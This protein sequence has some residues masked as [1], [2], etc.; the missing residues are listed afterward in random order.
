MR[1]ILLGS[2]GAGKGT[3]AKLLS[4]QCSIPQI[5]TGDMLR[6]A[7]KAGTKLGKEVQLV[8]DS[9]KL[10]SDDLIIALVKERIKEPDCAEGFL[11]DGFPRTIAQADALREAGIDIDTVIEFVIDDEE[12]IKRLS[13]RRIHPGS[14]RIYHLQFDPPK[15]EGLDDQT[16]EPLIQREDD[17]EETIRRRLQIYHQQTEPLIDYYQNSKAS[18]APRF[19]R[20]DA[21]GDV[22]EIHQHLSQI[23]G[24]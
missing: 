18:N 17:H 6:S 2:P 11:L 22:N 15:V 16:Q 19:L 4:K 10:V 8:M 7:V 9:G 14:G 23:L 21:T 3:Q 12:I 13:G 1:V 5:A 24:I 20:I